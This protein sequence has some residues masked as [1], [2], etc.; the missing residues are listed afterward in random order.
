MVTKVTAIVAVLALGCGSG[1]G[2]SGTCGNVEPCGGNLVGTWKV[3]TACVNKAE[4]MRQTASSFSS[5]C[6]QYSVNNVDQTT[7][8][9]VSFGADSTYQMSAMIAG[10][11]KLNL[12]VSCFNG[13]NC[14]Q[15]SVTLQTY[16]TQ[17]PDPAIQSVSCAGTGT[18]V[19]A[20]V[21]TPSSTN[22][23]GTYSTAGNTLTTTPTGGAPSDQD[24][25]VQGNSLHLVSVDT[26]M[27]MGPM[28]MATID[29]DIVATRQ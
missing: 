14:A 3:N 5:F 10:T 6:P 29:S 28:G 12:P 25:C 26:T 23:S 27:N 11:Y 16:F 18:C 7:S 19:C 4:L 15:A 22:E 17:N 13:M 1:S 2:Q 9:S 24:Y 21:A 20:I 8:G